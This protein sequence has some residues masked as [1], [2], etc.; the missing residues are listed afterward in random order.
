MRFRHLTI[1]DGLSQNA[2]NALL[3]D[4][5][6]FIWI[7][8]QD[9]LNRYDGY[10]FTVYRHDPFDP[11]TLSS[12]YVTALGEE[13][14]GTLWVGTL[15]GGL[16]RLDPDTGTVIRYANT[17]QY[18]VTAIAEDPRG[19][20][21]VGTNG[22]G[23][24]RLAHADKGNPEAVFEP[25][26]ATPGDPHSLTGDEVGALLVDLEGRLW[27]HTSKALSRYDETRRAFVRYAPGPDARDAPQDS[28]VSALVQTRDGTMWLGSAR[29][30]S[31]VTSTAGGRFTSVPFPA[32]GAVSEWA[33]IWQVAEG[34]DGSL[35]FATSAGLY[36]FDPETGVYTRF[37]H[38]ATDP[39][40]LSGDLINP[41]LWDRTGVLWLGTNGYGLDRYDAKQARF[42]TLR[43]PPE[44]GS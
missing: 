7:G 26:V 16:N 34:P 9:G 30:L 19:D 35:W 28:V 24:L 17:A 38:D 33:W 4:R 20:L 8:T 6:G 10:T 12:S 14:D 23:V 3:Q 21:W 13:A 32:P 15:A 36:R 27:V 29:G 41:L 31:R 44:L 40:S 5:Q 2:V 37:Q 43:R 22:G 25:F 18:H 39:G 1:E 42:Q 11:A